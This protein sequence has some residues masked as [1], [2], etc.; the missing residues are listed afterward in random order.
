[1]H[2]TAFDIDLLYES[3]NAALS[4]T[5]YLSQDVDVFGF[6]VKMLMFLVFRLCSYILYRVLNK[7]LVL[8]NCGVLSNNFLINIIVEKNNCMWQ[9][10]VWYVLSS[11]C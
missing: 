2:F 5:R 11:I 3:H 4:F 6:Q 7:F 10:F 9:C 1:M 8:E